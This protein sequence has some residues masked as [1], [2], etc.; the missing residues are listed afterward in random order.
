MPNHENRID[1]RLAARAGRGA[2]L[3]YLTGGYPSLE[4]TA[5]WIRRFDARG[6]TAMEIGFPY[7]D[8]IAD[9]PVIQDSFNRT[10]ADGL[11]IHRLF[12]VVASVRAQVEVAL[13]AMASYSLVRRMGVAAFVRRA[14]EAGFDGL[15]VPD[16]PYEEADEMTGVAA[17]RGLRHVMLVAATTPP[18][19]AERIAQCST[20]FVYQVA[21]RGTTGEREELPDDL[22]VRAQHLRAVGGKPVC[23]GFGISNASQVRHICAVADGA[24]VGSAIVR[25]ITES[26]DARQPQQVIVETIADFVG[27]LV[28]GI[29]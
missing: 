2:L 27:E 15:I 10:L 1:R 3:P 23:V 18:Q 8:S 21:I 26:L 19:R 25:R 7:S 28:E 14:G 4:A 16:L 29:R 12:D 6:V 11:R 22:R 20:G 13:L 5:E 9:G 17:T 24:I